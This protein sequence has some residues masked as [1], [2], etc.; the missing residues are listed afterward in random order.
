[1]LV[2]KGEAEKQNLYYVNWLTFSASNSETA[3]A[4]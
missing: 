4:N 1:V 2:F 3:N